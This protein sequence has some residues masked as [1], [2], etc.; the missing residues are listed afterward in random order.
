MILKAKFLKN[1]IASK[2][3][4]YNYEIEFESIVGICF[5]RFYFANSIII[6]VIACRK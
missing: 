2:F 1:Y 3:Q 5:Q 4:F 6:W